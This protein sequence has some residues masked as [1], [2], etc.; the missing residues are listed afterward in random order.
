MAVPSFAAPYAAAWTK[1]PLFRA[2]SGRDGSPFADSHS[3]PA[4]SF[5][6]VWRASVLL[7]LLRLEFEAA[8]AIGHRRSSAKMP[9]APQENDAAELAV[10]NASTGLVPLDDA[11]L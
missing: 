7:G 11:S 10:V 3:N 4:V 6:G 1:C 2:H 9:T 5:V 8:F